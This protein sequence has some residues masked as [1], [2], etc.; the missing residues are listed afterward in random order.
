VRKRNKQLELLEMI[1][2]EA[3]KKNATLKERLPKIKTRNNADH[4]YKKQTT[5][6]RITE[7]TPQVEL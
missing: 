5:R 2:E 4:E 1:S 7:K 6:D 3:E